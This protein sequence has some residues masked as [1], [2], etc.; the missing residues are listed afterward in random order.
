MHL[1]LSP[2]VEKIPQNAGRTCISGQVAEKQ[3]RHLE[4]GKDVGEV[5][6]N[7]QLLHR[8]VAHGVGALPLAAALHNVQEGVQVERV[9]AAH[10]GK[11]RRCAHAAA[12]HGAPQRHH[13]AP[14]L[15]FIIA[16]VTLLFFAAARLLVMR[17]LC[18]FKLLQL[19]TCP[20]A[21][22]AVRSVSLAA[23]LPQQSQHWY[24]L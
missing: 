3:A 6:V 17:K 7:Q 16:L 1:V 20:S 11:A 10:A 8:Q 22:C 5:G 24:C 19:L 23:G 12:R 13:R 18:S 15:H 4:A 21:S 14:Y 2:L 9:E